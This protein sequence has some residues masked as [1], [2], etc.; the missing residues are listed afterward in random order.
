MSEVAVAAPP[1]SDHARDVIGWSAVG[2]G[3]VGSAAVVGQ[4]IFDVG[5]DACSA[6]LL[7]GIPCPV[8]GL[9]TTVVHLA[10]A[11][12]GGAVAADAL[13][14]AFVLVVAVLAAAQIARAV[15]VSRWQPDA[16]ASGL[17]AVG[18]LAGHWL[19]ALTGVV[20]LSPLG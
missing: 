9:S 11:D 12:V 5:P 7:L 15:G 10:H 8:C 3:A 14:V 6:R 18:L 4:R 20:E 17:L 1:R 2:I 19:A 13:G 16:R